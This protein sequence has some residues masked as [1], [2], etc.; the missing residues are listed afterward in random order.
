MS[1]NNCRSQIPILMKNIPVHVTG[2]TRQRCLVCRV[3]S[4]GANPVFRWDLIPV[5]MLL[6]FLVSCSA[7]NVF[8]QQE[9]TGTPGSR[10][11]PLTVADVETRLQKLATSQPPA[12]L[13][14]VPSPEQPP[15]PDS[16]T[17]VCP[18]CGSK[19]VYKRP[20]T[21]Q[22]AKKRKTPDNQ[23]W[24]WNPATDASRSHLQDET[25]RE[26]SA[27]TAWELGD[28]VA[29]QIPACRQL[30]AEIR[31]FGLSAKLDES[32][33]CEKCMKDQ[34]STTP[35]LTF[36]FQYAGVKQARR[37]SK[38]K[39]DDLRLI[40]EFLVGKKVHVAPDGIESPL[41]NYVQRLSFLLGAQ[42]PTQQ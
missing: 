38:I 33:F 34:A 22:P 35:Y 14:K 12:H 3:T 15:L 41:K 5:L 24:S 13:S 29:R 19:T 23:T 8:S 26:A 20:E 25:E 42:L 36:T 39:S 21:E 2:H 4:R 31:S 30:T 28:L 32:R 11:T 10:M 17:Y 18:V 9:T 27:P 7:Q 37:L 16:V 6:A 1:T 40:A